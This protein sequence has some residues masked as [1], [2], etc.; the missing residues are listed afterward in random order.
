MFIR[1][2]ELE[3]VR[4]V[5]SLE[6]LKVHERIDKLESRRDELERYLRALDGGIDVVRKAEQLDLPLDRY[7]E[8][9]DLP[10]ASDALAATA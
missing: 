8:Q 6:L 2:K 3:R 5:F 1:T 9:M 7:H 10:S 4:E